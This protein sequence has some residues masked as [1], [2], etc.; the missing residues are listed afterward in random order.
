M[1]TEYR[2]SWDVHA[3]LYVP[4]AQGQVVCVRD[5]QKWMAWVAKEMRQAAID[6]N[7]RNRSGDGLI[8]HQKG[9]VG[10]VAFMLW[11]GRT[12]VI[13]DFI[14]EKTIVDKGYDLLTDDYYK[15]QTRTVSVRWYDL[16]VWDM[17]KGLPIIANY[18][19]AV[20]VMPIADSRSEPDLLDH[21]YMEIFGMIRRQKMLDNLFEIEFK[22]NNR[23]DQMDTLKMTKQGLL[24]RDCVTF[25]DELIQEPRWEGDD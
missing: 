16:K 19:A 12:P 4:D 2:L 22:N 21:D 15:I 14:H 18:D 20:L 17:A 5:W 23:P 6:A 11:C 3:R 1:N 9:I 25:M 7:L 24:D 10:E 8:P 13:S